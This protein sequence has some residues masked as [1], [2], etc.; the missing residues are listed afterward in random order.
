[1]SKWNRGQRNI[2]FALCMLL[3][4]LSA[5]LTMDYLLASDRLG[6]YFM[7]AEG[8]RGPF[9]WIPMY[10]QR[11]G[12]SVM[13]VCKLYIFITNLAALVGSCYCFSKISG[14]VYAGIAGSFCYAFSVYSVYVRYTEGSLGEMTAFVFL[15][16][17]L[18]GMWR[19]Y[20]EDNM[21]KGYYQGA[22]LLGAGLFGVF[23][24][25]IPTAMITAGFIGMAAL[26]LFSRTFRARTVIALSA[27]SLAAIL[28]SSFC[29]IPYWRGMI[30]VGNY[31]DI[32]SGS[33]FAERS[34]PLAQLLLPFLGRSRDLVEPLRAQEYFGLGLPFL[35]VI[36][37]WLL[38]ILLGRSEDDR[39][40]KK[41]MSF[42]IGLSIVAVFFA[43]ELMPWNGVAGLHWLPNVLLEHI[44]YPRRFTVVAVLLLSAAVSLFGR[45]V[46]RSGRKAMAVFLLVVTVAN[47][48]SG[49]YL[50]NAQ[51]YTS[52][53]IDS[54]DAD[55][56]YQGAEYLFYLGE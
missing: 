49:V 18:Y 56:R 23:V 41:S 5:P 48:L 19:L 39:Q 38:W 52:E 37:V 24:S 35:G 28:A 12:L 31:A 22:L 13:T 26:L 42:L 4:F 14:N 3:L 1:M 45:V 16:F 11:M 25:H 44:G 20:R 9:L 51:V 32:Q 34:L 33:S 21:Q 55:E 29:W 2:F 27:G 6:L 54:F 17:I 43:T 8:V 50:M 46:W 47:V 15:P 53:R 36:A 10:L 30:T 7:Q 40:E